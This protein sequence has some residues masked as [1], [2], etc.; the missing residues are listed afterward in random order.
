MNPE[1]EDAEMHPKHMEIFCFVIPVR[2]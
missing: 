2:G 1:E